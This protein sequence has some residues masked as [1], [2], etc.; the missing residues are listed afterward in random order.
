[1]AVRWPTILSLRAMHES[2]SGIFWGGGSHMTN[3]TITYFVKLMYNTTLP[4]NKTDKITM[5]SYSY[6]FTVSPEKEESEWV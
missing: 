5:N 3:S 6:D 2:F 1:M 4:L